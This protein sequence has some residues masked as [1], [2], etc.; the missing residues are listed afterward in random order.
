MLSLGHVWLNLVRLLDFR[1]I[2]LE[3]VVLYSTLLTI[4]VVVCKSRSDELG[5]PLVGIEDEDKDNN[6][7]WNMEP[8]S[9]PRRS[10]FMR[11]EQH[12]I[13]IE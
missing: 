11:T 7:H 3:R 9:P 2:P 5:V 4:A 6:T 13:G 10:A 12:H 8:G 1:R